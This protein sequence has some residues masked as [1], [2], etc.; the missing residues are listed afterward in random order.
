MEEHLCG[1]LWTFL[2]IV[3]KKHTSWQQASICSLEHCITSE[4]LIEDHQFL[5]L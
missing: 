5:R 4:K 2:D 1:F 3:P